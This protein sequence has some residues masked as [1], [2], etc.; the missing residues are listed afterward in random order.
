MVRV[1]LERSPSV[2]CTVSDLL[3]DFVH[4]SAK[5]LEL[6]FGGGE[7]TPDLV[8]LFLDGEGVEAHLEAGKDRH[9]GRWAGDGDAAVLL[10]LGLKPGATDDLGV[11]ALGGEEHDGVRHGGGRVD[12]FVADALALAADGAFKGFAGGDDFFCGAGS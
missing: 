3:F 7:D 6:V 4:E 10:N 1:L 12:V 5:F 8:T 2:F 9:E 11:E